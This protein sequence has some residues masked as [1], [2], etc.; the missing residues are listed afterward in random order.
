MLSKKVQFKKIFYENRNSPTSKLLLNVY[1]ASCICYIVSLLARFLFTRK[2]YTT[3]AHAQSHTSFAT[4]FILVDIAVTK[5]PS[6]IYRTL[7]WNIT[8]TL[9]SYPTSLQ[10][11]L[12]DLFK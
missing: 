7:I 1:N 4:L 9:L 3:A 5:I 8:D 6:P 10:A 2:L 12:L 11:G